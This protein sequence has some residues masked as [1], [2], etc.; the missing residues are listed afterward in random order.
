MRKI[1]CFLLMLIICF[2]IHNF[3]VSANSDIL[4]KL[5]Y[6]SFEVKKSE[7]FTIQIVLED[8]VSLYQSDVYILVDPK[9]LEILEGFTLPV[10]SSIYNKEEVIN[11]KIEANLLHLCLKANNLEGYNYSN[12]NHLCSIKFRAK[13]DIKDVSKLFL[14]ET[15]SSGYGMKMAFLNNT[16]NYQS[17]TRKC[18]ES[19]K[20]G[21]KT[22]KYELEVNSNV[23]TLKETII[24]DLNVLN[25]END[26]YLL[27]IITEEV[28]TTKLGTY[29]IKAK[30]YDK[31]TQL[32]T[33][34]AKAVDVVD[35]TSPVIKLE[36]NELIIKD[37]YIND[38][39]TNINF[40]EDSNV[41]GITVTDNYDQ[42]VSLKF[43]YF[44]NNLEEI[45]N[46]QSFLSYL[47]ENQQAR[48]IFYSVDES[49][50]KTDEYVLDVNVLDTTYPEVTILN[51]LEVVDTS[52]EGF[53]FSKLLSVFDQYDKNP[54]L[55][56]SY[57]NKEAQPITDII[58]ELANNHQITAVYYTKDQSGNTSPQYSLKI[59]L[60]DTTS[61]KIIGEGRVVMYDYNK[62]DFDSLFDSSF[63]VFDNL[64]NSPEVKKMYYI[65]DC[66]VE[67]HEFI[68]NVF[69]GFKGKVVVTSIDASKNESSKYESI[70]EV[71]DT[72][73]PIINIS[74]LENN[75]KYFE[76][77]R[78]VYEV[79]D[80]FEGK[81]DIIV[82]LNGEVYNGDRVFEVGDYELTIKATDAFSNTTTKTINFT[83]IKDNL[84]G[85]SDDAECYMRNYTEIIIAVVILLACCV[86]IVIFRIGN[87]AYKTKKKNKKQNNDE[88]TIL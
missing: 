87:K 13:E 9:K 22:E 27:E 28:E 18:V 57:Y 75:K 56:I 81:L 68:D 72:M 83:I 7:E 40:L 38:L 59:S 32:T 42:N 77:E 26:E 60:K 65:D 46:Y 54:L 1:G 19:L 45:T 52:L 71:I 11:N 14:S 16:I 17:V 21:W 55:I 70:V 73:S 39:S 5:V 34:Y 12:L 82:L 30:C 58:N 67:E 20:I 37:Q 23:E 10:T 6:S 2:N 84:I 76:Q 43:K 35:T 88:I 3:K 86:I 51:D 53:N 31:I 48:V 64:D 79:F 66:V 63:R 47:K 74:H 85:C 33:F 44:N 4:V 80:N 78:I 36:K 49:D 62:D 8:Y 50:N 15:Y 25:R 61:P 69:K 24:N 41:S 29:V